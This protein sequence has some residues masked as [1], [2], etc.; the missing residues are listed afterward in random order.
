[1]LEAVELRL[2]RCGV[3]ACVCE[4]V[5]VWGGVA[6]VSGWVGLRGGLGGLDLML[7]G[8]LLCPKR[9][10]SNGHTTPN[11]P[12]SSRHPP[13]IAANS[14]PLSFSASPTSRSRRPQVEKTTDLAA[15]SWDRISDS[16][17]SRAETGGGCVG[18]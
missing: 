16:R 7:K 12:C 14:M 10:K 4:C 8:L 1:V 13:I 6:G 9:H 2:A 11:T 15:G 17:A 18:V 3:G 5:C